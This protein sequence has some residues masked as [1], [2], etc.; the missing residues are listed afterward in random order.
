[1]SSKINDQKLDSL[2]KDTLS[3]QTTSTPHDFTD[4]MM[5][6]IRLE[7]QRKIIAQI[8][9]KE[10]LALAACIVFAI[11]TILAM[12]AFTQVPQRAIESLKIISGEIPAVLQ[13]AT[14]AW[15]ILAAVIAILIFTIAPFPSSRTARYR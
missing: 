2:L 1:M 14:A 3:K 6:Q 9:L 7:D 11:G 15:Q 13:A 5:T 12:I 4:R 10:R 8:V